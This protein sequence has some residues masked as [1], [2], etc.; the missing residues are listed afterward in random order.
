VILVGTAGPAQ[1][2]IIQLWDEN[3]V[4]GYVKYAEKPAARKRLEGERHVLA[5]LPDSL[6]PA[7]IKYGKIADGTGLLLSPIVGRPLA[8]KLPRTVRHRFLQPRASA[9]LASIK[10]SGLNDRERYPYGCCLTTS[11]AASGPSL[12]IMAMLLLNIL[13]T[14]DDKPGR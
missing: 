11:T 6:G 7:V 10:S 8:P 13:R 4:A 9:E 5:A 12:F 2:L 14:S 3:G 1:K